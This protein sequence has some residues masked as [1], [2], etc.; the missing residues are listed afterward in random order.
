M[1]GL[2]DKDVCIKN[3]KTTVDSENAYC[4]QASDKEQIHAAI[5]NSENGFK[6]INASVERIRL[7]YLMNYPVDKI[8]GKYSLNYESRNKE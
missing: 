7:E 5:R 8:K 6:G 3:I 1:Y 4:G 2:L